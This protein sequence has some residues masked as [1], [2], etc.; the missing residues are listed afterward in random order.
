MN[1]RLSTL[2]LLLVATLA[3]PATATPK[4]SAARAFAFPVASVTGEDFAPLRLGASESEV[5]RAVG[6]PYRRLPGNV[7]LFR[8]FHTDDTD[9]AAQNGC[10]VLSVTLVNGSVADMKLLNSAAEKQLVAAA[11]AGTQV[12][13]VTTEKSG[14][15][16]VADP[17]KV[18]KP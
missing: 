16:A 4:A 5:T 17:P 11:N 1:T 8:W 13:Y 14:L 9:V 2:A 6:Y 10:N 15:F 18:R 3:A 7:A 12:T